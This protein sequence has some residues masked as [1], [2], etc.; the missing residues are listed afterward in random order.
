MF[1]KRIGHNDPNYKD[2]ERSP[3]FIQF[4]D[5]VFQI[6]FQYSTAFEF[7]IK[8]LSFIAR[9]LYSCKYGTF[10]CDNDQDRQEIR[11]TTISLWTLLDDKTRIQ[12][13]TNPQYNPD[14]IVEVLLPMKTLKTDL[15][16]WKSYYFIRLFD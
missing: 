12:K 1:N 16:L 8:Y 10:L 9:H 15:K 2:K 7:N 4:M 3:I 11:N 5:S 13:F 14:K 6:L